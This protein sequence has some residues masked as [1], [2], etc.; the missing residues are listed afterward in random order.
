ML[1]I[2]L[3]GLL[4]TAAAMYLP[5]VALP[6]QSEIIDMQGKILDIMN[7]GLDKL[8]GEIEK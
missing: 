7:S 8:S 6:Y 2:F 1:L 5:D 4:Y 3:L